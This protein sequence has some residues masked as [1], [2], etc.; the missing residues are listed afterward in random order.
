VIAGTLALLG[1]WVAQGGEFTVH[2]IPASAQVE[3]GKAFV[4][5]VQRVCGH[6]LLPEPWDPRALSPLWVRLLDAT[7]HE[8]P[9][10]VIETWRY[11][12]FAFQREQLAVP[13]LVLRARSRNGGPIKEARSQALQFTIA[14][15]LAHDDVPAAELPGGLLPMP[16]RRI[17]SWWLALLAPVLLGSWWWWQRARTTKAAT[18]VL[19]PH[20][21]ALQRLQALRTHPPRNHAESLAAAVEAAALLR[22]YLEDRFAVRALRMTTEELAA[23]PR[24]A[25]ALAHDQVSA[26]RAVLG[27]GDLAKFARL[28]PAASHHAACCDQLQELLRTTA[29]PPATAGRNGNP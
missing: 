5:T 19:P 13:P 11:Q 17:D 14:P 10:R 7:R 22:D 3:L 2:V 4:L 29:Q 8:A 27:H 16:R 12:A 24:T 6:D 20:Q 28:A 18:V 1:C 23:D 15:A 26:V 25:S 21:R 9:E